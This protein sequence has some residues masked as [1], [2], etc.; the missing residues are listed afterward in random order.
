MKIYF[1]RIERICM[2]RTEFSSRRNKI[3]SHRMITIESNDTFVPEVTMYNDRSSCWTK[4]S[5]ST[6]STKQ[7]AKV[8]EASAS[9]VAAAAAA[10]AAVAAA[11]VAVAVAATVVEVAAAE[12]SGIVAAAPNQALV[13]HPTTKV[14]P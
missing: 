10:A 11:A 9:V 13:S 6:T 14:R 7:R 12:V 3:A 4:C 8:V 5:Q 2:N 1:E